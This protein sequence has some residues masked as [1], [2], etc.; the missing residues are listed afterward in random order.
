MYCSNNTQVLTLS[1]IYNFRC[2]TDIKFANINGF[3]S[4]LVLTG[5]TRLDHL[6]T[7]KQENMPTYYTETLSDILN[8]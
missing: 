7:L 8:L 2:D 3:H 1:L 5:V 6:A 4:L